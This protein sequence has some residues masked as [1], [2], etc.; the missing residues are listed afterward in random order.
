MSNGGSFDLQ[1]AWN[2]RPPSAPTGDNVPFLPLAEVLQQRGRA[3]V[4]QAI[5]LGRAVPAVW[6]ERMP[7]KLSAMPGADASIAADQVGEVF[8]LTGYL[9]LHDFERTGEEEGL[10]RFATHEDKPDEDSLWYE[11]PEAMPLSRVLDGG[12]LHS[13]QWGGV[14]MRRRRGSID[15]RKHRTLQLLVAAMAQ[16]GYGHDVTALRG[17]APGRIVQDARSL[18]LA[19]HVD[20]ARDAINEAIEAVR[21]WVPNSSTNGIVEECTDAAGVG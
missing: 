21:P 17:D 11:L 5:I 14:K 10:F 15:P 20:T 2:I 1:T 18:G 4:V 3:Q 6:L 9:F 13:G 8:P 16:R 7:C 19:L 12:Y